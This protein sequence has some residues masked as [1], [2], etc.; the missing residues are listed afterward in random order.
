M[1]N[2]EAYKANSGRPRVAILLRRDAS[3]YAERMKI[4][5]NPVSRHCAMPAF[6]FLRM[7]AL[8]A[9]VSG[10]GVL[11][12]GVLSLALLG[13]AMLGGCDRNRANKGPIEI[14]ESTLAPLDDDA[15]EIGAP[16]MSDDERT[17]IFHKRL[18]ASTL[19][20]P[21][22]DA[23]GRPT[24]QQPTSVRV[25]RPEAAVGGTHH[26]MLIHRDHWI[27][28][29]D[30]TLL[31]LDDRSGRR[32]G[33]VEIAPRGTT[34]PIIDTIIDGDA[35]LVLLERDAV[36]EV[37][38]GPGGMPTVRKVR[39]AEELGVTPRRLAR[40]GDDVW[41]FGE[42]GI[43]RYRDGH[44]PPGGDGFVTGVA[45]V[46]GRLALAV[47][48]RIVWVDEN[49]SRHS[50]TTLRELPESTGAAAAIS[51]QTTTAAR[52]A[53]L[54]ER[55]EET[56]S[57][58]VEGLVRRLRY[59]DDRLWAITDEAVH[60]WA[61]RDGK[62]VDPKRI[63]VRGARDAAK[64]GTNRIAIAGSFGR[65]LYRPAP[66]RGNPGDEFLMATRE[67]SRLSYS[68]TDGRRILAGSNE[69]RWL[70]LIGGNAEM[71]ERMLDSRLPPPPTAL[72]RWGTATISPDRRTVL[73]GVDGVEIR[74]HDGSL[75]VTVAQ[76]DGELWIGH[77]HGIDLV[78][79][80]PD[81]KPRIEARLRLDGPVV[82]IYPKWDGGGVY[83]AE[84]GGFGVA[85]L[86]D[87]PLDELGLAPIV[88]APRGGGRP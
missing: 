83:V 72:S 61:V 29:L 49:V 8:S 24:A 69:G 39:T 75:V 1:T 66:E 41:V 50:A 57:D 65:S 36:V 84:F 78:G 27:Q 48:R 40:A 44:R 86:V 47:N 87:T 70:Y 85:R 25:F 4:A 18:V 12:L 55:L 79:A 46:G 23:R 52:I 67:A 26:T 35:L 59:R 64:V 77:E 31:V 74:P 60:H 51:M 68:V 20:P 81:G 10:P 15:I 37:V 21:T 82:S 5:S 71:T 42:G 88:P 7:G 76:I 14:D 63:R 43:V 11:S 56:D 32:I 17:R 3:A 16:G 13:S 80:D 2:H 38:V 6:G 53:L 34:G 73:L 22:L 30:T 28:S 54:D 62:L 19:P 58:V 9:A 45:V 33:S